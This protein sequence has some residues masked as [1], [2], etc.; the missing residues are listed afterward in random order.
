MLH[1]QQNIKTWFNTGSRAT[2]QTSSVNK[3]IWNENC[4]P[5]ATLLVQNTKLNQI[6]SASSAANVIRFSRHWCS[7]LPCDKLF[8]TCTWD[9]KLGLRHKNEHPVLAY[10][11]MCLSTTIKTAEVKIRSFLTLLSS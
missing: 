8:R 5:E 10:Q 2:Q 6:K 3:I 9:A 1:G 7:G 4:L 11:Q